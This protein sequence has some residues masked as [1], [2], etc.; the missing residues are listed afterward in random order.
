[1]AFRRYPALAAE[2][3]STLASLPE[4]YA[5]M[6]CHFDPRGKGLTGLPGN[7][8]KGGI[9][10]LNDEIPYAGQS[11]QIICELLKK[12]CDTFHLYGILLDFLRPAGAEL[13]E[14]IRQIVST[15]PCPIASADTYG[16][17]GITPFIPMPELTQCPENFFQNHSGAW[18]ELY[19]QAKKYHM[20]QTGCRISDAQPL[21]QGLSDERLCVHYEISVA[22]NGA[23][24][25]MW[26]N[27]T[28]RQAL[29]DMAG[30][31][32]IEAVIGLH[33]ELG[34]DWAK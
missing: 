10:I 31:A 12:C 27:E 22:D 34:A 11:S 5:W 18:L 14:V 26:R 25:T 24:I 19:P 16:I 6:A 3:V 21:A 7:M 9:L 33:Q 29:V 30:D 1:M 8:P 20:D 28:D 15:L 4:H 2:E 23:D 32:G 13:K 17:E